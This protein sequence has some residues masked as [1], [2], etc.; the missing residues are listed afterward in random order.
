M[1]PFN[2]ITI[3]GLALLLVCILSFVAVADDKKDAAAKPAKVV[4]SIGFDATQTNDYRRL[5]LIAS[6]RK[7]AVS[8]LELQVEMAIKD[9]AH[10]WAQTRMIEG[11]AREFLSDQALAAL[12][13]AREDSLKADNDAKAFVV[14]LA[15]SKGVDEA[16]LADYDLKE[17][18]GK[19]VLKRRP[20]PAQPGK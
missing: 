9:L 18:E 4:E 13:K 14:D 16:A 11:S 12:S 10:G 7:L 6:N 17:I 1:K 15:K 2:A 19:F 5:V 20:P 3:S 8:N